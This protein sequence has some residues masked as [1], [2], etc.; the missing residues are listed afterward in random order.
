MAANQQGNSLQRALY[1]LL[2]FGLIGSVLHGSLAADDGKRFAALGTSLMIAGSSFVVGALL[3]VLFGLPKVAAGGD[4]TGTQHNTN[5]E[6]VSDWLTKILLGAG[7]TQISTL[8]S[9]LW[10]LS[11]SLADAIGGTQA[12][13]GFVLAAILLFLSCGFLLFYLWS[14]TELFSILQGVTAVVQDAL[15]S[16]SKV[17]A[18]ARRLVL[19]QLSATR[20]VDTKL[21]KESLV[22]ALRDASHDVIEEVY[23]AA[24]Q[25]RKANW[26]FR[27]T[28]AAPSATDERDRSAG[29]MHA[30]IPVLEALVEVDPDDHPLPRGSWDSR[31]AMPSRVSVVARS[32][33]STRRSRCG[34]R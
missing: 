4:K 34:T 13:Q 3:G 18:S 2:A 9:R 32:S 17:D 25:Q 11:G 14:R 19:D 22:A 16:S 30:T 12:S 23:A 15:R 6:E 28:D 8:S 31:C 21:T 10:S 27:P 20:A 29:L 24:A 1:V 26:Q 5:L 33:S 7:L